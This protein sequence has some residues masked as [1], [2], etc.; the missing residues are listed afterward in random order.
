MSGEQTFHADSTAIPFYR[1]NPQDPEGW[2]NAVTD[3][4]GLF[5][6]EFAADPPGV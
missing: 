3:S 6:E 5:W 2:I 4:L 1:Q